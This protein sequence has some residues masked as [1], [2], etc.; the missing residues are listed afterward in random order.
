MLLLL[1]FSFCNRHSEINIGKPNNQKLILTKNIYETLSNS[2]L[3]D[4]TSICNTKVTHFSKC[5]IIIQ[6]AQY[7]QSNKLDYENI[8]SLPF[9]IDNYCLIAA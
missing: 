7:N 4:F 1:L 6:Y 3:K 9:P 8:T 2:F 5:S